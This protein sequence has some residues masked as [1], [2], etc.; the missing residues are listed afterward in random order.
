MRRVPPVL[1]Q[2]KIGGCD[3]QEAGERQKTAVDR[4]VVVGVAAKGVARAGEQLLVPLLHVARRTRRD[5][6]EQRVEG[7][8]RREAHGS[9]RE[10]ERPPKLEC[11]SDVRVDG[12]GRV[13]RQLAQREHR[14]QQP[15]LERVLATAFVPARAALDV[16]LRLVGERVEG[17]AHLGLEHIRVAAAAHELSIVFTRRIQRIRIASRAQQRRTQRCSIRGEPRPKVLAVDEQ[18]R[19]NGGEATG[20]LVRLGRGDELTDAPV[21]LRRVLL[22]E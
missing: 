22:L 15:R 12:R 10:G 9:C 16:R 5:A 18:Q 20:L 6:H 7:V 8:G 3:A 13:H 11:C 21:V 19:T 2:H 14:H 17:A 4:R 1:T